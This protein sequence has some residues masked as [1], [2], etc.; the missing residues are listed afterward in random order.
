MTSKITKDNLLIEVLQD[1]QLRKVLEEKYSL[2][3]LG[4]PFFSL[5]A[6]YLTL[7]DVAKAYGINLE[8]LISDLNKAKKSK[9]KKI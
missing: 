3:C 1:P 8:K 9:K 4:C 5:E 2:P 6:S 7:G